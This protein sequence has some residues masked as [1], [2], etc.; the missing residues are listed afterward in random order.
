MHKSVGLTC[1]RSEMSVSDGKPHSERGKG[2]GLRDRHSGGQ[3]PGS[4][5]LRGKCGGGRC[6]ERLT[7]M[8]RGGGS[9]NITGKER[10]FQRRAWERGL[11]RKS[12]R[13]L[14]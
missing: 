10:V 13:N 6:M 1:C 14:L 8:G 11:G 2:Q 3:C 5:L 7:E 9:A 12:R 4:V